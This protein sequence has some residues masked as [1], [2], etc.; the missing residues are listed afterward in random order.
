MFV[1]EK[2][3]H[4]SIRQK[5][6]VEFVCISDPFGCFK[7]PSDLNSSSQN[8]PESKPTYRL[9]LK[10]SVSGHPGPSTGLV[11]GPVIKISS[12]LFKF[13]A[14]QNIGTQRGA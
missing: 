5:L 14:S 4:H 11:L 1:N 9:Y 10:N 12:D 3:R 8:Y 2:N 6:I 13:L 7:V